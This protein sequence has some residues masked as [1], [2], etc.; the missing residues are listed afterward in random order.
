MKSSEIQIYYETHE[1]NNWCD[2]YFANKPRLILYWP[3]LGSSRNSK[4]QIAMSLRLLSNVS[5]IRQNFIADATEWK[6]Q[7]YA[8]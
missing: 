7:A 8:N 1:I 4:N 6:K 3:D 2:T 5:K